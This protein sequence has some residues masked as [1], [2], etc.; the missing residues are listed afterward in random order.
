MYTFT[1]SPEQQ[2]VVGRL[3]GLA[4]MPITVPITLYIDHFMNFE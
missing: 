2:I 4:L 1:S 3:V